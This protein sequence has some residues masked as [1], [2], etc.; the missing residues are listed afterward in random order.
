MNENLGWLMGVVAV[1]L[2][3]SWGL[4]ALVARLLKGRLGTRYYARYQRAV[5]WTRIL[6]GVQ[7]ILGTLWIALLPV[8][9]YSTGYTHVGILVTVA[10]ACWMGV[11]R[12]HWLEH[13]LARATQRREEAALEN[14]NTPPERFYDA[15]RR[16]VR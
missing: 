14:R 13:F 3:L 12:F 10:F 6:G 11:F 8:Y 7:L 15:Q 16:R 1:A 4:T 9:G 2:T 5:R